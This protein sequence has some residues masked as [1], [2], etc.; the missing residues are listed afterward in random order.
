[1]LSAAAPLYGRAQEIMHIRPLRPGWIADAM[2][3]LCAAEA[4]EAWGVWGGIPRYWELAAGHPD[5]MSAMR[6]L[7]LNPLSPLYAE[8]DRL[9][10]DELR[11]TTQASSILT[12]VG[13][14]VHRLS[15]VAGRIERPA[16]SLTRPISWL[17]ELGLLSREVP[18]GTP[19][20]DAKRSVYRI[21]DQFLAF[22]YR[23]VDPN[24][25]RIEAGHI[26]AVVAD[27]RSKWDQ[28]LGLVW[29]DLA[30][31]SVPL[32]KVGDQNWDV[33]SRWWGQ[34]LDGTALELDIVAQRWDDPATV[35]VGEAKLSATQSECEAL[36][37]NILRRAANCPALKGMKVVPAVWVMKLRGKN[38]PAN[39]FCAE[40][41]MAALR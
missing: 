34:G 29:E 13:Q 25:S 32:L 11:D 17:I 35:L 9:L 1:V 38:R 2:P 41:V 28:Y 24:R 27:I 36:T 12:L 18:F 16:T 5:T 33:A 15:E 31:A 14:G 21:A 19:R 6:E 22:W 37:A 4:C 7:V 39:V 30:R 8:P 26:D 40:H 10:A 3:E 20:R 23:F